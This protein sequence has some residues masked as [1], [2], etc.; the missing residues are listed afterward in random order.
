MTEMLD[1]VTPYNSMW[2]LATGS[3]WLLGKAQIWQVEV[4]L[5]QIF[6]RHLA[7]MFTTTSSIFPQIASAIGVFTSSIGVR[8]RVRRFLGF[9][10]GGACQG[11]VSSEV[12]SDV[13]MGEGSQI[14]IRFVGGP[15]PSSQRSVKSKCYHT[16]HSLLF[17]LRFDSPFASTP[18]KFLIHILISVL[19]TIILVYTCIMF[20]SC[21]WI[22]ILIKSHKTLKLIYFESVQQTVEVIPCYWGLCWYNFLFVLSFLSAASSLRFLISD[23]VLLAELHAS[24]CSVRK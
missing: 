10:L 17:Q 18:M 9:A 2:W 8:V 16:T 5:H 7:E 4:V 15:A 13:C 19:S 21:L 1:T 20:V 11:R 14:L 23:L 12:S 3:R 22:S 24:R 6:P